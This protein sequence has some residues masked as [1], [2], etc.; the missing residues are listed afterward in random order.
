MSNSY[1]PVCTAT[2]WAA[3]GVSPPPF[4]FQRSENNADILV[5]DSF[6]FFNIG[7]RSENNG[8]KGLRQHQHPRASEILHACHSGLT[9]GCHCSREQKGRSLQTSNSPRAQANLRKN[10]MRETQATDMNTWSS[11]FIRLNPTS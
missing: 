11:K 1:R 4:L 3:R 5:N 10:L 9:V 8:G 7:F 6:T 2:C